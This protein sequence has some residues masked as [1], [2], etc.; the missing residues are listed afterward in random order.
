MASTYDDAIVPRASE[1]E[2]T[3]MATV[4]V[5]YI[6]NDVDEAVTFYCQQLGFHEETH[7]ALTFAMLSKGDLRLTLSA[8]GR[9]RVEA[10][11]RCRTAGCQSPEAGTASPSKSPISRQPY[12]FFAMQAPAFATTS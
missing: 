9:G 3:T 7:P 11:K 6:V 2:R 12:R 10:V 1:H 8:P 4:S 5:R